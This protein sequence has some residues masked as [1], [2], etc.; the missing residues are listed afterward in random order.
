MRQVIKIFI[1]FLL[2][3]LLYFLF[4]LR[5]C[6]A[7][8]SDND[9][10]S[11][12]D[13]TKVYYT[14]PFN[15]D[16]DGDGY[17]DYTEI[18]NGYSPHQLKL[19]MSQTD[20]DQDGLSDKQER[21][22]GTD[23]GNG[24]TDNDGY[25]DGE[26]IFSGH[27]PKNPKRGARMSG[28]IIEISI[29]DQLLRYRIGKV[30]LGEYRVSTGSVRYPTPLGEFLIDKKEKRAYSKKWR[31]WMPYFLSMKNGLFGIH[32]LPEWSDGRKEGENHLGQRVSHGCIRLGVGPAKKIYDWADVGTKVIIKK[33]WP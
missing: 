25:Q 2:P 19:K 8:D 4:F 16:T 12:E 31:L 10:V 14:N 13:E 9:R 22:L 29:Q 26:E 7:L 28:K 1:I 18:K 15:H 24:D 27:D 32:E 23:L 5:P 17:D 3:F 21:L 11:D 20:L 6:L 33:H 30:I